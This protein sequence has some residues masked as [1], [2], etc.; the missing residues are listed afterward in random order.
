M[1]NLCTKL[2]SAQT[3]DIYN[4]LYEPHVAAGRLT[5]AEIQFVDKDVFVDR[6]ANSGLSQEQLDCL[7]PKM[8]GWSVCR[9]VLGE[10]QG[11]AD[12]LLQLI[13]SPQ[14]GLQQRLEEE[15]DQQA[16]LQLEQDWAAFLEE[17]G[18]HGFGVD[19]PEGRTRDD[20][21]R[22]REGLEEH[23]WAFPMVIAVTGFDSSLS[24]ELGV[25]AKVRADD[26]IRSDELYEARRA[27]LARAADEFEKRD[28]NARYDQLAVEDNQARQAAYDAHVGKRIAF[29]LPVVVSDYDF[30][31]QRFT[32]DIEWVEWGSGWSGTYTDDNMGYGLEPTRPGFLYFHTDKTDRRNSAPLF[33]SPM[34]ESWRLETKRGEGAYGSSLVYTPFVKVY[35]SMPEQQARELRPFVR[36]MT[37]LMLLVELAEPQTHTK[38]GKTLPMRSPLATLEP[39]SWRLCPGPQGTDQLAAEPF[40]IP[41]SGC[42]SWV[43]VDGLAQLDMAGDPARGTGP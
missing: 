16:G 34:I 27:E 28:I 6:C 8:Q 36:S 42:T 4:R 25:S 5:E 12:E 43:S 10:D 20:L 35:A 29:E 38:P 21:N 3:K 17:A 26:G 7:L 19:L 14:V 30:D 32:F 39:V 41:Q 37:R 22:A 23:I 24:R 13:T 31:A 2:Y 15:A 18:A 11:L 9:D 33:V 40:S 1:A